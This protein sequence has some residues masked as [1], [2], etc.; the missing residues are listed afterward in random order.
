M[1]TIVQNTRTFFTRPNLNLSP[2]VFKQSPELLRLAKDPRFEKARSWLTRSPITPFLPEPPIASIRNMPD[3]GLVDLTGITDTPL[4]KS[5]SDGVVLSL[6]PDYDWNYVQDFWLTYIRHCGVD[7]LPNPEDLVNYR[8]GFTS[9]LYLF[10]LDPSQRRVAKWA[11]I[12]GLV[13]TADGFAPMDSGRVD[14][15]SPNTLVE[16]NILAERHNFKTIINTDDGLNLF[17]DN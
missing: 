15:Q 5:G 1:S 14:Y 13:P 17:I 7:F 11:K 9:S 8:N 12:V 2:L 6:T 3:I 10:I 16:F 4:E